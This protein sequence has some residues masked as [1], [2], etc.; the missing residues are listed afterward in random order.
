[1]KRRLLAIGHSIAFVLISLYVLIL[2]AGVAFNHP[3]RFDATFRKQ[4]T[5]S[6]ETRLVL[7]NLKQ[8]IDVVLAHR[9]LPLHVA[10][11]DLRADVF[12]RARAL[13]REY[14]LLSDKIRIVADIDVNQRGVEWEEAK[15]RYNLAGWNRVS[16]IRDRAREDVR[17]EEMAELELPRPG[18]RPGRIVRTSIEK[19][20][21]SAIKRLSTGERRKVFF[22]AQQ[23][24]RG[25]VPPSIDDTSPGGLSQLRD[26]LRASNYE[27]EELKLA[28]KGKVPGDCA[29]LWIVAPLDVGPL[30]G[31][32]KDEAL[33]IRRY[34]DGGGRAIVAAHPAWLLGALGE[35][36]DAFGVHVE[37]A[38]ILQRYANPLTQSYGVIEQLVTQAFNE[39]HA[40]TKRL[41]KNAPVFAAVG[42]RPITVLDVRGIEA[43]P[44]L[45][46]ERSPDI[47]GERGA[48][49][50]PRP[51]SGDI[52]DTRMNL[53]VAVR[54]PVLGPAGETR[55]ARIAVFGSHTFLT[56]L[57][58]QGWFH[59]DIALNT[60]YW[61]QGREDLVAI[62]PREDRVPRIEVGDPAVLR[63]LYWSSIFVVPG[64]AIVLGIIVWSVRRR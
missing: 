42:A 6:G 19:A 9:F 46:T 4:N 13:L 24:V 38:K 34:L 5:L 37:D 10:G 16:F 31:I 41:P 62:A 54:K 50:P 58:I 21:T 11:D 39:H 30:G 27:V 56:N 53:A 17:V 26:E 14:T 61:A 63:G 47:W 57:Q 45:T 12:D 8:P 20:F 40:A 43:E 23:P 1:M 2:T 49:S 35:V 64:L 32:S 3:M 51:G 22:L 60:L 29:A 52:L 28:E 44:L 55:E 25:I 15:K 36:L 7:E 48:E 18:G 33:A 59:R